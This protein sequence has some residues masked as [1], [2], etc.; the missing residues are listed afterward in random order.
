MSPCHEDGK[1]FYVAE[2]EW[3][4]DESETATG[5]MLNSDRRMPRMFRGLDLNQRPLG[6][7]SR[8]RCTFSELFGQG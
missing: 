6:Y 7:E 2:G 8:S 1:K 5:A 4:V 3:F